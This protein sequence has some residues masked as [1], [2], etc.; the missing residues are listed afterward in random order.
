MNHIIFEILKSKLMKNSIEAVTE[1]KSL[2][3]SPMDCFEDCFNLG[4]TIAEE[5]NKRNQQQQVQQHRAVVVGVMNFFVSVYQNGPTNLTPVA[6][7]DVIFQVCSVLGQAQNHFA[8]EFVASLIQQNINNN[9]NLTAVDRN[10]L[11]LFVDCYKIIL[12]DWNARGLR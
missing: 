5:I 12:N 2:K 1:N 6:A 10:N 11:C 9:F 8:L 7:E 3:Y 4:R